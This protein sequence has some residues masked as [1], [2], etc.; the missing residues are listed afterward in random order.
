MLFS[1]AFESP[2]RGGLGQYPGLL[3]IPNWEGGPKVW[4]VGDGIPKK[5]I[6]M[7]YIIKNLMPEN[8]EKSPKND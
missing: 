2:C 8:T 3:G 7:A 4:V 6:L 5:E 1:W